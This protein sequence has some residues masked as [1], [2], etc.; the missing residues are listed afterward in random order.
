M[1][2]LRSLKPAPS[3]LLFLSC[4]LL[5]AC[6]QVPAQE[7]SSGISGTITDGSGALIAGARVVEK[8]TRTN[9]TSTTKT[10]SFGYYDFP[11]LP[12][13]EYVVSVTAPGFT[14]TKSS[15]FTIETGQPA[16][17]DLPMKIG[18]VDVTVQVTSAATLMNTTT[19][20]LGVTM[21]PQGIE[22][23][24]VENRNLFDLIA[25]QP[26]VN[27]AQSGD[28]DSTTQNARGG[29]EVNGAPGLSNSIL[30][31][32][33]DATF[34]EDNGAGAGNQ[35][36]INTVGLGAIA[37]FRT[38][39]SV[40]PVQYGRAAGGVLTITTKSG[41]NN[42]HGQIFE[43]FRNDLLDANTWQN[44]RA[45][46]IVPV[47]EL[48]FNEFGANAGGPIR[49]NHSFF[50]LSYEGSRIIQG[51]S[52]SSSSVPSPFLI[53]KMSTLYPNTPNYQLIVQELKK[54]PLPNS[55][56]IPFD[57]ANPT[58]NS[59]IRGTWT[60][61]LNYNTIED[62]GLARI[63]TT[64]GARHHLTVRAN[65]NNQSESEQQLRPDNVDLSA[66]PL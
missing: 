58:V 65:V 56:A 33:V 13:G 61:N 24:P 29:F 53:W 36:A 11:V 20:E 30:L 34:G 27:S 1:T 37:E 14:P 54:M 38:S 18:S 32:G 15:P 5:F 19:N 10:N 45:T 64:L 62:T 50:F 55:P 44:K 63:D 8:N 39:S 47:P 26:G 52:T 59:G 3:F 16:R 48:R 41:A 7:A 2:S 40:P 28:A 51:H 6:I 22:N 43:Y 46:R 60:G 66:A 42:L 4:S 49:H 9:V 35:V 25:L 21:D 31:D 17:I 23:L 57:P 12:A